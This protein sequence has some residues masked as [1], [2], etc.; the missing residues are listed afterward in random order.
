MTGLIETLVASRALRPLARLGALSPVT[1][2]ATFTPGARRL[3]RDAERSGELALHFVRAVFVAVLVVGMSAWLRPPALSLALGVSLLT[4]LWLLALRGL[5]SERAFG[6]VR[7]L[8]VLFDVWL[9]LDAM[10]AP[11]VPELR[12]LASLLG[13]DLG[14]LTPEFYVTVIPPLLVFV[15]LSSALRLDPPVAALTAWLAIGVYV[16]YASEFAP[17]TGPAVLV[18]AIVAFG[19]FVG[20][21][22]A[23]VV[24]YLLLKTQAAAVLESYVPE[25]LSRDLS[26][27]G[28]LERAGRLEEVTLLLCDLRGFTQVSERL[29]PQET[30]SFVNAYLDAVCPPIVSSG[31]VIDKFMGDGVLAFFEGGGHAARALEAARR[32]LLSAERLAIADRRVRVGIALHSGEVLIGSIGPRTR[33]EYTIISDAVNTVTRLEELNKVYGSTVVA[34]AATIA[35]IDEQGREGFAGPVEVA[36]RGRGAGVTVYVH[37]ATAPLA[38]QQDLDER[39]RRFVGRD[40]E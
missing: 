28:T 30:V 20:A 10:I 9:V 16:Y 37:G 17:Q 2:L 26:S 21:N 38:D 31:G 29:S 35:S 4:L 5:R 3:L 11:R 12:D 36:V 6:P 1:T 13:I 25:S 14:L 40:A 34:S 8:L 39:L 27:A 33:R 7:Y 19:G 18:G 15:A 24:R 32:I 22:M 23:R